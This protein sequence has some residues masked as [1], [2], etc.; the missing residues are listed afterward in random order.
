MRKNTGRVLP[1]LVLTAAVATGCAAG[2]GERTASPSPAAGRS[3]VPAGSGA[4]EAEKPAGVDWSGA[5]LFVALGEANRV[6]AVD[7]GS[8]RSLGQVT[9]GRNHHGLAIAPD[10][11]L[12][13]VPSMVAQGEIDLVKAE[14]GEVVARLPV[15][16]VVHHAAVDS[17]GR[18]AYVAAAPD[19]VVTVDLRERRVT[20][21][22]T[23][24]AGANYLD[25]SPD[26]KRVFVANQEEG[27]VSFIDTA[28]GEVTASVPVG[29]RPDHIAVNRAGDRIYVA[30][31]GDGAVAE[32]AVAERRILRRFRVGDAPHGVALVDGERQLVATTADKLAVVDLAGGAVTTTVDLPGAM[33]H[34][35]ASPDGSQAWI[36]VPA[37]KA[38]AVWNVARKQL[39]GVI[40]LGA[41]PHQVAIRSGA[42]AIPE[43]RLDPV[44]GAKDG[45]MAGHEEHHGG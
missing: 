25:V 44:P 17:S 32:V 5:D 3:G 36:S 39:A 2:K 8:A 33:A 7:A 11:K 9:V 27:T 19:R 15:G 16:T 4:A 31:G 1:L 37:W 43:E 41:P 6:A 20:G 22:I 45:N 40:D 12:L 24:G 29:G 28:R 42:P 23:A 38:L 18:T 14:T 10:G 21:R 26:G 30:L 35:A 13:V 34:V